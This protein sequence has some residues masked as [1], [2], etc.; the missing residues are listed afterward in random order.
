MGKPEM[1][2]SHKISIYLI[3]IGNS[4]ITWHKPRALPSETLNLMNIRSFIG[5]SSALLLAWL[6]ATYFREVPTE[7]YQKP[8]TITAEV[9]VQ[10]EGESTEL[11]ADLG[12]P[13][14]GTR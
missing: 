2:R 8:A 12:S 4:R 5:T 3:L 7:R 14:Q 11:V 6:G 1:I 10:T 13:N 9:P